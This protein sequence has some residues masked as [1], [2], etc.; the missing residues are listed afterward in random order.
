M[1]SRLRDGV[2][3]AIF[4]LLVSYLGFNLLRL[5]PFL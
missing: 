3:I 5:T 1:P 4:V 2:T